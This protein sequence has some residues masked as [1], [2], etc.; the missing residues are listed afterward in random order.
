MMSGKVV[1]FE[2]PAD[3][4]ERARSFYREAFGWQI[5]PMPEMDNTVATADDGI[6]TEPGAIN[7]G[8]FERKPPFSGPVLTIDVDDIDEALAHVEKAGGKVVAGRQAV[9]EMG[10]TG[11]FTDTEGNIV[12][13]W[14]NAS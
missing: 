11:Y 13:V 5:T 12:G 2:I 9:G 14:Q 6:P 4:V 1:H 7:G 10:Y 3:N 8:L